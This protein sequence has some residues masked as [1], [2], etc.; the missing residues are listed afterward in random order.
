[1][2]ALLPL[3]AAGLLLASCSHRE[4]A[5]PFDQLNPS[6]SGRP[7][8]FAALA[9]DREVTLRWQGVQGTTLTGY[10]LF[11][12][13]PGE[14]SFMALTGSLNIATTGFRDITV[15][16]GEEYAYRLYFVFLSGLGNLP[17]EDTA[18]PGTAVPWLVENSGSDLIRVTPDG[19]RVA[20]RRSGYGGTADVSVNTANGDVWVVDA[21]LGRVVVYYPNSGVT[22]TVPGLAF[23]RS[24]AADAFDGTAW[25]CDESR[26]RVYHFRRDGSAEPVSIGGLNVPV[27]VA[28][29]QNDGSVWVCER[30]AGRVGRYD[31]GQPLWTVGVASPSRVAVDSTTHDGWVT[32]SANGTVAHFSPTGQLLGT[33]TG[34]V[35]PLGVAIDHRRGRIWIADYGAGQVIAVGRDRPDVVEFRVAGLRDAGDLGVDLGTGEAWVVLGFSG[36]LARLST[37]GA[38]I[39]TLP[40]FHSPFAVSVDPGGR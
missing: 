34:F 2:R 8:G 21:G 23:P 17:A 5:N 35:S 27:D 28:V 11:R 16:N 25:V 37:A 29:D 19:R 9:G 24:V 13:G 30:G 26:N 6:S 38:V 15:V 31:A 36:A 7:Q 10:Q 4:R 20:S 18:S 33:L 3:L 22:V 32:S 40:G 1:M 12:R 14:A 39:R